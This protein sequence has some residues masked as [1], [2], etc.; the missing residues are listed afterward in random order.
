MKIILLLYMTQVKITPIIILKESIVSWGDIDDYPSYEV[1]NSGVVRRK[2]IDTV[3]KQTP[4]RKGY[5]RVGLCKNGVSTTKEVHRL[6]GNAFIP[7]EEGKNIL[8][9]IDHKNKLNNHVSNLR[10]VTCSQ[11][12]INKG[13]K[14]NNTSGYKGVSF[15]KQSGLWAAYINVNGK[16]TSLRTHNTAED[17]ARAYDLKAKELHGEFAVLNFQ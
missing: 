3:L 11:S 5:L 14:S 17:A 4:N 7:R 13:L 10:W 6:V 8:D 12:N 1:S 15:H 2:T 16:R 9:H